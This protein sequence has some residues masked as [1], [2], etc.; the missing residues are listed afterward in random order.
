MKAS[1]KLFVLASSITAALALSACSRNESTTAGQKVD[2]AI[3][4]GKAQTDN[5]AAATKDAAAQV[6]ATAQDAT[7][8]AK[9][10]AALVADDRL[11]A[12][13]IDVDTR[14]GRVTLTGAAPDGDSRDRATAMVKAIE[15]VTEVNNQLRIEAKS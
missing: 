5:A 12:T 11:R 6:A 10:N 7:I 1:A 9:A 3:A 2:K 14:N 8:T 4:E 13:K 15:G